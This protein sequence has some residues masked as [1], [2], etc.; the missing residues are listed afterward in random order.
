[1][2]VIRLRQWLEVITHVTCQHDAK[3]QPSRDDNRH[4]FGV[5][6]VLVSEALVRLYIHVIREIDQ[7]LCQTP[8]RRSVIPEDGR[9]GGITQRFR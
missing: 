9:E 1:M 5:Y 6:A 3:S 8:L 2:I 7:E 4:T